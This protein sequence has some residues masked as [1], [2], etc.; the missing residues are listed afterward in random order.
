MPEVFLN[1]NTYFHSLQFQIKLL[2]KAFHY[3]NKTIRMILNFRRRYFR[4]LNCQT[5]DGLQKEGELIYF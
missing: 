4:V 5:E 2:E 3:Q 1:F